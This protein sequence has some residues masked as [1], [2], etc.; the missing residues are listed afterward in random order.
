MISSVNLLW[1][2]ESM[3][4]NIE[5]IELTVNMHGIM[6]VGGITYNSYPVYI[7]NV[8]DYN[9]H[10]HYEVVDYIRMHHNLYDAIVYFYN[11]I[12][13]FIRIID[14]KICIYKNKKYDYIITNW[15]KLK[16]IGC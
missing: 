12:D 14:D 15:N 6:S 9:C 3:I 13:E 4:I 1:G 8:H 2:I 7:V 10:E 11:N 5:G 16:L